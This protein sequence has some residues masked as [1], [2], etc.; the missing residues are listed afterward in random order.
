[1]AAAR[2]PGA[3][4]PPVAVQDLAVISV[5][6]RSPGVVPGCES[7]CASKSGGSFLVAAADDDGGRA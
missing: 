1:M 2:G 4:P 6:S 3:A 7:L 5:Y